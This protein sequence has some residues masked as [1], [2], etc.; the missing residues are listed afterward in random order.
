MIFSH[1]IEFISIRIYFKLF[2]LHVVNVL[3]LLFVAN[4]VDIITVVITVVRDSLGVYY[5]Q[6]FQL[7][8]FVHR[9]FYPYYFCLFAIFTIT[10]VIVDV[11][12]Q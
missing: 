2:L 5:L 3:W 8:Y 11:L 9:Y 12:I 1:Y 7:Y 6:F 10:I 4:C